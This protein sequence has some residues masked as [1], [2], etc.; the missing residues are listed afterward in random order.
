MN[1]G[2]YVVFHRNVGDVKT[3]VDSNVNTSAVAETPAQSVQTS[4]QLRFSVC[5]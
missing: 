4:R 5:S 3:T 1:H 2:M